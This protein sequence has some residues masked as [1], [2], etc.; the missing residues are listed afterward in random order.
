MSAFQSRQA[1]VT[2]FQGDY[3]DR[4]QHLERKAKAAAEAEARS[5]LAVD[6]AESYRLAQEHDAL[7]AEA[8]ES[9]VHVKVQALRRSAWKA[10]IAEHPPREGNKDDE[11]VGV[12]EDTFKDALVAESI[13]EPAD[14]SLEDLDE[15][16]DVDFDR[17]YYAAFTLNRAPVAD[18]K[19][20]LAS[21]MTRESDATSN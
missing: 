7:V 2:I 13:V 18:P 15:L 9:A 16:S 11:A 8:E 20:N 14:L 17:L 4:I 1:V 19:A 12:N 10:L 21:Q 3:L 5:T 6:A